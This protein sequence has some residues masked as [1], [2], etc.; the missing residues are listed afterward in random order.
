MWDPK[1][2]GDTDRHRQQTEGGKNTEKMTKSKITI[3]R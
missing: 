3:A 1:K 2:N